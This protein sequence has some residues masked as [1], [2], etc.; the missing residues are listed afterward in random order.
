MILFKLC[1]VMPAAIW[2]HTDPSF[3][4]AFFLIVDIAGTTASRLT[5][6]LGFEIAKLTLQWLKIGE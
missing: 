4:E 1:N 2:F 5:V 6:G 3:L